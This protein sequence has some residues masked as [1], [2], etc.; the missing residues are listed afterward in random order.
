M[1]NK[2]TLTMWLFAITMIAMPIFIASCDDDGFEYHDQDATDVLTTSSKYRSLAEAYDIALKASEWFN[3]DDAEQS[4]SNLRT[5]DYMR[6]AKVIRKHSSRSSDDDTL[7]YVINYANNNGFAIVSAL[8]NTPELIAVTMDGNYDP[9]EPT[10]NEGFDLYIDN[11]VSVLSDGLLEVDTSALD[12]NGHIQPAIL[13]KTKI[14]T[15]WTAKIAPKAHVRW[16]QR[17]PAG[18]LCSNKIAGCTNVALAMGMLGLRYPS[19]INISVAASKR[20]SLNWDSLSVHTNWN[21]IENDVNCTCSS[22]IQYDIALL[23]RQLGYLS[24]TTYSSEESSASSNGVTKAIKSLGFK[25]DKYDYS[26]GLVAKYLTNSNAIL[27]YGFPE[28]GSGHMWLCDGVRQYK[29]RSRYYTS[30]D[31]G[32]TWTQSGSATYGDE[33]TYNFYNWGWGTF[34]GY[35]LDMTFMAYEDYP[36]YSNDVQIIVFTKK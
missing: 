6:P 10:G 24:G 36:N 4:R 34:M 16:G 21:K 19:V 3:N 5:I 31:A 35:Y 2:T 30:N 14:D 33:R 32:K 17:G 20:L 7:M 15:V 29:I 12:P 22:S 28:N 11:A 13:E 27:M 25:Y 23:C 18:A 1:N 26:K 9:S 8:K